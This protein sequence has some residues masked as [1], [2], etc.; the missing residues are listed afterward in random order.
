[1]PTIVENAPYATF[2]NTFK[3]K[4]E[5]QDAVVRIN[6]EIIDRVAVGRTGFISASTHR[7][8]DGTRVF[9]YLQW[10]TPEQLMNMQQS[11]EFRE[12]AQRLVGLI[13]FEPHQ[14]DVVHVGEA[15]HGEN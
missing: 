2:I 11:D 5:D 3:C 1:M 14:C 4:P 13:E 7:S 12:V 6:V 9:N 10:E 15:A 8:T